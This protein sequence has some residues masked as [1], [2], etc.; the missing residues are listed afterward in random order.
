[1]KNY[2][3]KNYLRQNKTGKRGKPGT[4]KL[5]LYFNADKRLKPI[6]VEIG[7]NTC[8]ED[9]ALERALIF[10]KGVYALGGSFSNKI[11]LASFKAPAVSV[12][13]ILK[14]GDKAPKP[15]ALESL[16]LFKFSTRI[17]APFSEVEQD[18]KQG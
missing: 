17:L 4:F 18:K 10:L 5:R 11:S 12:L 2:S 13:D 7:L 15:E 16:P 3:L 8:K 9:E 14:K 1:M 6:R